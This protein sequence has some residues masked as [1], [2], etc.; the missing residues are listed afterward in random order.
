MNNELLCIKLGG[1]II[2]DKTKPYT[3]RRAQIREIAR[4]LKQYNK[5]VFIVHGSGSFG[6]TSAKKFGGKNGYISKIGIAT[7]CRDAQAI[8]E[9]VRDIF[10][11][12]ELPAISFSPR[13][14]FLSQKGDMKEAMLSPI[15]EAL[16]QGL[17]PVVYGDVIFDTTQQTTIF[18]GERVL[19]IICKYLKRHGYA[20]GQIIQL[21]DVHGV[22]DKDGKVIPEISSQTWEGFKR[23]VTRS[24]NID[25]T[26]G[27]LHKVESSLELTSQGIQTIIL[28]GKSGKPLQNILTK[29]R[30]EG[31]TI[32]L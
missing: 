12:E 6:H 8:N 26:G 7:V 1:S 24:A 27:M 18:S 17:I 30:K 21:C 29:K 32:I 20:V 19:E 13:S 3:A 10:I 25:V 16:R 5:P 9:I 23:H 31:T 11:E 4:V 28:S 15:K 2:T 14:F 22:L